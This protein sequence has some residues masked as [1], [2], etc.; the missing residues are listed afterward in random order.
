MENK[1]DNLF[2]NKLASHQ[3]APSPH[4]WERLERKLAARKKG[5]RLSVAGLAASVILLAGLVYWGY[6]LSDTLNYTDREVAMDQNSQA[7]K[8]LD[9]QDKAVADTNQ[10]ATGSL[11]KDEEVP[12]ATEPHKK[13]SESAAVAQVKNRLNQRQKI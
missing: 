1:L 7:T 8:Q 9:A 2:K 10:N 13:A 11:L 3:A 6:R 4:T 5:A 12:V